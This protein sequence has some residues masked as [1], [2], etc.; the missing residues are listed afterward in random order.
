MKEL[1]IVIVAYKAEAYL[2]RLLES[3][4]NRSDWEIIVVDNNQKNRG[5]AGGCNTGAKRAKGEYILFLNPDCEVKKGS[6]EALIAKIKT[7][8][9]I[10]II[11]PQLVDR[12]GI[13]YLST[14]KQPTKT[15]APIVL[16][17]FN[18]WF[19]KNRQ[20]REYW[21][22]DEMLSKERIVESIS[23]AAMMLRLKDFRELGGFDEQFFMYW[24]DYDLCRRLRFT[25]KNILFYPRAKVIHLKAKSSDFKHQPLQAAFRDSRYRFFKKYY[26]LSYA[27]LLELW[28]VLQEEWRLIAIVF[29]AAWL[30]FDRLATLMPLIPDQARDY[31]AAWDALTSHRLPLLGIPSSLPRFSQGPL[32]IWFLAFLFGTFGVS[33]QAAGYAAAVTGVVTVALLYLW[34]ERWWN[35]MVAVVA[36]LILAASPLAVAHARM[37]FMINPI[38]LFSLFYLRALHR[39][40]T[41]TR[42]I[43]WVTFTFALLFQFELAVFPL[44]GLA[45]WYTWR[46]RREIKSWWQALGFGGLGLV[47]GLL[48]QIV[49]D[50]SHRFQ[51]VGLFIGWVGYRIV[52]F[53]GFMPGRG[54]EFHKWPAVW[55]LFNSYLGKFVAWDRPWILGLDVFMIILGMGLFLF[56]KR[57]RCDFI[58]YIWL[59]MGLLIVSFYIHGAP[60]EAYFPVLFVPMAIGVA[61]TAARLPKLIRQTFIGGLIILTV[62]NSLFLIK[63]DYLINTPRNLKAG[64]INT[65]GA[66][67][68]VQEK[69]VNKVSQLAD[70]RPVSLISLGPGSEFASF[71]DNY[72]FLLRLKGMTL[73]ENGYPVWF[74]QGESAVNI[75]LMNVRVYEEGG[76][77]FAVPLP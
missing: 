74:L 27:L 1:S 33:A 24:E 18:K 73:A 76:I 75:P 59:W 67:L 35:R 2:S 53:A 20:S 40:Y 61:W 22:K 47:T 29:L 65:Y 31:L 14:T 72:R 50:L 39:K 10:G 38:P 60:S 42:D 19:S 58:G 23:G 45:G 36:A 11:G 6:I 21:Y 7:D 9:K 5:F 64:L 56:R 13:A 25:G 49:F 63:H 28:L 77:T 41:K 26:G 15:N 8:K 16:S 57:W 44:I 51:Q 68:V 12:E 4:P 46:N 66:P 62:G 43:F 3:I 34:A 70:K 55:V 71:L 37:A 32:Y 48:P 17:V 69:V 54:N 52:R 30:R